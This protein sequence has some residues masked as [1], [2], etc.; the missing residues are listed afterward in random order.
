MIGGLTAIDI[1]VVGAIVTIGAVGGRLTAIDFDCGVW[2][3]TV[4]MVGPAVLGVGNAG[5]IVAEAVGTVGGSVA[6]TGSVTDGG[7]N[8][9][10]V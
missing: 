3:L 7:V 6:A 5:A 2:L 10:G 1:V 4:T 9:L 8:G